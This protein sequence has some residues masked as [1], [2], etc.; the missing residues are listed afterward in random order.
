MLSRIYES[1][2]MHKTG[3]PLRPVVSS[4]DSPTYFLSQQY[5]IMLKNSVPKPKSHVKNSFNLKGKLDN[6]TTPEGHVN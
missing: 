4:I 5:D 3:N 6:V 2:K 1:L